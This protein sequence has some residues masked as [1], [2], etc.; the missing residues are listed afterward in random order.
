MRD[1]E[2]QVNR[3]VT[4]AGFVFAPV[5]NLSVAFVDRHIAEGRANKV[6]ARGRAWQMTFGELHESVQRMGNVFRSLDV[7]PGDRVML[8]ARDTKAFFIGFLGAV[9]IGAVVIPLQHVS[10]C[11]RLC[12]YAFR[13]RGQGC[14]RHRSD[15]DGNGRGAESSR[16]R[17]RA[18]D[19]NRDTARRLAGARRAACASLAGLPGRAHDAEFSLLLALFFRVD[20]LAQGIGARTQGHDLHIRALCGRYAWDDRRRDH[21]LRAQAVLRLWHRQFVQLS[22]L[23]RLYRDSARGPAHR[24]EHA[25]HDRTLQANPVFRCANALCRAGGTD[26]ER[27]QNRD[28]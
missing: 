15:D 2:V 11:S 18:Q 26:G 22:A 6:V 28:G 20:R 9:R 12:L 7:K 10:A 8:L 19:C 17:S 23:D 3:S 25:R 5:F 4:P 24:R 21:L 1:N 14:A 16:H 13:L 27:P